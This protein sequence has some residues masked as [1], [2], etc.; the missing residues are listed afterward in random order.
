[1]SRLVNPSTA[2]SRHSA[3]VFAVALSRTKYGCMSSLDERDP[4]EF[5]Q[6]AKSRRSLHS[7]GFFASKKLPI[8]PWSRYDSRPFAETDISAGVQGRRKGGRIAGKKSDW[9]VDGNEKGCKICGSLGRNVRVDGGGNADVRQGIFDSVRRCFVWASWDGVEVHRYTRRPR[10]A[11][12]CEPKD[13]KSNRR[14][15]QKI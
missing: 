7:P 8:G 2:V 5:R 3:A 12:N 11:G 13:A 14:N 15:S 10:G 9:G 6:F 1:M 4:Q